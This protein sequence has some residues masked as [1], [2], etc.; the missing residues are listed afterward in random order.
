MS[1]HVST[2]R[3][4]LV[5]GVE[6]R[7]EAA[8]MSIAAPATRRV[9]GATT[10][11]G[12]A[13]RAAH[14]VLEPTDARWVLASRVSAAL[15]GGRAAVLPPESR[16]RL[17]AL[18]RRMG[19]RAFDCNLI[20]A[21]VQDHARCG[22]V[23]GEPRTEMIQRLRLVPG[24]AGA[25]EREDAGRDGKAWWAAWIGATVILAAVLGIAGAMWVSA[26]NG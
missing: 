21:I 7:A 14:A 24:A 9:G 1:S 23:G 3:L 10:P 17:M 16:T 8:R 22:G 20:I 11:I 4:R 19:L 15:Q 5:S 25:I 6:D 2:V 12:A 26:M 13:A 18:G